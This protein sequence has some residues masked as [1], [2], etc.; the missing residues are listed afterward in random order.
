MFALSPKY[1][2]SLNFRPFQS[3]LHLTVRFMRSKNSSKHSRNLCCCCSNQSINAGATNLR[4]RKFF[5][6]PVP[7]RGSRG[8]V[9]KTPEFLIFLLLVNFSKISSV[10]FPLWLWAPFGFGP[11]SIAYSAYTIALALV[12]KSKKSHVD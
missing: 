4:S 5:V 9:N 11:V 12:L 1:R 7:Q 6:R 10:N 8:P 2:F 3:F